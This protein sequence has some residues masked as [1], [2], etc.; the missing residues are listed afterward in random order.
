[1]PVEEHFE[2][3]LW[4]DYASFRVLVLRL[5]RSFSELCSHYFGFRDFSNAMKSK[6]MNWK[7]I[8]ALEKLQDTVWSYY[9]VD[10]LSLVIDNHNTAAVRRWDGS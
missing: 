8:M 3:V 7:D 5:G 1:M 6:G 2:V 10:C 4:V 9:Y